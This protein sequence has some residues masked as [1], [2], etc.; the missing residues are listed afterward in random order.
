MM[1]RLMDAVRREIDLG[2]VS[3]FHEFVPGGEVFD[4]H[5]CVEN[6]GTVLA[7]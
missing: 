3:F 6:W 7:R 4:E 1:T 5:W 2:R